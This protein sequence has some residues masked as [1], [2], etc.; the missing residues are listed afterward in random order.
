MRDPA[1]Y[2]GGICYTMTLMLNQLSLYEAA[3]SFTDPD[4]D[5]DRGAG[6]FCARVFGEPGRALVEYLPLLEP[7]HDWGN[8]VDVDPR[9]AGYHR[10]IAELRELL[11][12]LTPTA[13]DDASLFPS[14]EAYRRELLFFAELFEA[15]SGPSPDDERLAQRYWDHVYGIYDHLPRHVDERP[16]QATRKLITTFRGDTATAGEPEPGRWV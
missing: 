13:A 4:A 3:V 16:G 12:S 7:V 6:D 1:P 11:E 5:P 8:Y 10:R 9:S 15:L 14:P 2:S